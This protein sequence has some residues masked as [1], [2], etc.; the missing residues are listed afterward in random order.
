[1]SKTA[2]LNLSP[3]DAVRFVAGCQSDI[4]LFSVQS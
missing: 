3:V 2:D 1:M 4:F